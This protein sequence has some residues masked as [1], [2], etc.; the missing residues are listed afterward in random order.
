[1]PAYRAGLATKLFVAMVVVNILLVL[2]MAVA[3]QMSFRRGFLGYLA[4]E[5]T[6]RMEETVVPLAAVYREH[7][8]WDFMK[9]NH[10]LWHQILTPNSDDMIDGELPSLPVSSL[11]GTRSRFT[12]ID[13]NGKYVFGSPTYGPESPRRPI[14]VDGKTVGWLLMEP[15]M[16]VTAVGDLRFQK[17]QFETGVIIAVV[18]ILMMVLI[19]MWLARAL[20]S[21]LRRVARA[22]H[23]LAEGEYAA[24]V[25]EASAGD[26]G[27]LERDF[28][29]LA[30]TLER[31][32]QLRAALVA[33][34]SHELRTPLAIMR[35][36]IEAVQVGVRELNDE[37]V[38]SIGAEVQRLT[39]L[40]DDLYDLSLADVGALR[41]HFEEVDVVELLRGMLLSAQRRLSDAGVVLYAELP[42]TPLWIRAD[43]R[44]LEQ[45]FSNLFENAVRYVGRGSSVWLSVSQNRWRVVID[46]QDDGPGVPE[47][48]LG[49]LFEKFY[50]VESSRS[51]ATGGAGLGLPICRGIVEAHQGQIDAA[52]SPEGG[53]WVRLVFPELDKE[54]EV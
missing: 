45:V 22:T 34:I 37:A 28:N 39:R 2:A 31:N 23:Q 36:E 25:P 18:A 42:S 17:A 1:M 9:S 41:Y 33:D 32:E 15:F 3:A 16:Q 11:I 20:A 19:T 30:K 27:Q 8:N 6:Q 26:I 47:Q 38:Q 7:G 46:F 5:E 40:V 50:R 48:A 35:G 29:H 14:V 49:S 44:R 53:L 52:K 54:E 13:Q 43:E 12:L 10:I 4:Q 21:P 24:R 51:R